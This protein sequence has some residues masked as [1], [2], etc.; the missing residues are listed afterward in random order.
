V[1]LLAFLDG[2]IAMLHLQ[3]KRIRELRVP[4]ARLHAFATKTALRS[5]RTGRK[6]AASAGLETK[7]NAGTRPAFSH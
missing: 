1:K 4:Q 5:T 3:D 2:S 6:S 7:K